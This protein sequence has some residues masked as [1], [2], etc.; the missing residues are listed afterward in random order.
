VSRSIKPETVLEIAKPGRRQEPHFG[1][2][3]ASLF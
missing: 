1:G 2:K 3:L